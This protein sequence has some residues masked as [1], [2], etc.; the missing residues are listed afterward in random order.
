MKLIFLPF[1]LFSFLC[2][3]SFAEEDG[4]GQQ[5]YI[6]SGGLG[7]T[8]LNFPIVCNFRCFIRGYFNFNGGQCFNNEC[9]C[10]ALPGSY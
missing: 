5:N 2:S 3:F 6:L 8:Y 10:V 4:I 9:V 1:V 7:C